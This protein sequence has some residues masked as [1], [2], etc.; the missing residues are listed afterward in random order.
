MQ[1]RDGADQGAA[2]LNGFVVYQSLRNALEK[3]VNDSVTEQAIADDPM[4][5]LGLDSVLTDSLSIPPKRGKG[6]LAASDSKGGAPLPKRRKGD[7]VPVA[8]S[9]V[10]VEVALSKIWPTGSILEVLL[11]ELASTNALR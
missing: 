9:N 2:P 7:P 10:T 11:P 6:D 4:S 5:S 1:S 8:S 3:A